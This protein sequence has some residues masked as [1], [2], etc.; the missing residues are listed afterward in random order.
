VIAGLV[1]VTGFFCF[2]HIFT[3]HITGNLVIMAVQAVDGGP[4]HVAQLMSIPVFAL[5]VALAYL[6]AL[7]SRMTDGRLALL[8]AQSLMLFLVLALVA[9]TRNVAA[10]GLGVSVLGAMLAVASMAFQNAFI[11]VSLHQGA[12]TSTMTGNVATMVIALMALA[13]PGPWGRDEAANKLRGTWPLFVG[14]FV[15]CAV[16]TWSVARLGLWAWSLPALLSL[17]AIPVSGA[18]PA[19]SA[20]AQ[21]LSR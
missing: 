5:T 13:W 17:V 2:G 20:A 9:R 15:G 21:Q 3:A 18:A 8:V 4:P 19:T 10:L 16:A 6:L 7:R 11:R 1:D 12:T 14:F